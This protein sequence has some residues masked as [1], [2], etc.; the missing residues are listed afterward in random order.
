MITHIKVGKGTTG[1][2]HRIADSIL[3]LGFWAGYIGVWISI[4]IAFILLSPIAIVVF[5][6]VY[7]ARKIKKIFNGKRDT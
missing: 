3:V 6:F 2:G 1:F 7:F 4:I 5:P